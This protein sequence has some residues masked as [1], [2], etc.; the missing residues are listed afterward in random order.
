MQSI[1]GVKF[2]TPFDFLIFPE[3]IWK[4]DPG[5]KKPRIIANN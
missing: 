2:H 1:K 3:C 4:L 5:K